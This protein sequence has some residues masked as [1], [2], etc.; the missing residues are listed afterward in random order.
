MD[1]N[2]N[3]PVVTRFAPSPTGFMHV[4]NVRTALFAYLFAR[5]QNGT[6]ILRIEDT[7]KNREVEGSIAHILES[8][9]WLEID[10]DYGPDKPGPFGACLQSDR[11]EIYKKYAQE[12]VDKGLAYP[13][14]YTEEEVATFRTEAEQEKRPFLFRH[15]R[16]ETM[17]KWDGT[18]PL[19]F[20]VPTIKRYEWQDAVRGKLSAGEEMLDDFI[21]MKADGYPTYNFAHIIDDHEMG[22]THVMRGEE[23]IASTP[24][25][26]SLYDALELPWP[27]FVTLPPIMGPDG[28]KKL[29]KRDGAKDLLEYRADGYLPEAMRNFLALIGWNPGGNDEIFP[30]QELTEK[31]SLEKIQRSGGAFNEEKLRWMNKEYLENQTPEFLL[32]YL[33]ES[34]P[35]TLFSMPQYSLERLQKLVPVVFERVHSKVDIRTSAGAGEYDFAFTAPSYKPE[36]LRWKND[37]GVVA[38]LPRL[39]EAAKLLTEADFTSPETVKQALWSYADEV[40][41]GELLWPLRTALSGK[42]RSPD[43]F[44]IA[45]I[46]GK[47]ETLSR[48]TTACDKIKQ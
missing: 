28:K 14:P 15:H 6:F 4:G 12:L 35:E 18:Q 30:T 5:K 42:E 43:P 38:A 19:R 2:S 23:F 37:E 24:K 34:L 9:R 20:K 47:E 26:L 45:Y 22:V 25:F 21:I 7:D 36:L 32:H 39:T 17:G 40:G 10:W 27:I 33:E 11:L 16:P 41:R 13:D 46:I 8:L 1:H 29:G 48:I 3:T 31:F 44:M